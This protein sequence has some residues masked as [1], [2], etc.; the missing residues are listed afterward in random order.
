MLIED[1]VVQGQIVKCMYQETIHLDHD[2]PDLVS[3]QN[4]FFG[5][6]E[7]ALDYDVYAMFENFCL[8]ATAPEMV[9]EALRLLKN[10][11]PPACGHYDCGVSGGIH[12]GPTFGRGKCDE[13]GYWEIPCRICAQKYED[14]N[15]GEQGWPF[16]GQA[17]EAED[18]KVVD[19]LAE[20]LQ[21]YHAMID[22]PIGRRQ[23]GGEFA[24]EARATAR[25]ALQAYQDMTC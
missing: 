13:H 6:V 17:E 22:S 3:A 14:E 4:D 5:K 7:V 21:N 23:H 15:P 16:E 11:T 8:K 12:E 1:F 19:L 9:D 10:K 2:D 25:T 18:K 20:A 24:D